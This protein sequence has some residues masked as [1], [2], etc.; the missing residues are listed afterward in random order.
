MQLKF[1]F[2]NCAGYSSSIV[3]L[4]KFK[5]GWQYHKILLGFLNSNES[6]RG[7]DILKNHESFDSC[8]QYRSSYLDHHFS[9]SKLVK[10]CRFST[11][12]VDLY[13]LDTTAFHLALNL[14]GKHLVFNHCQDVCRLCKLFTRLRRLF[15]SPIIIEFLLRM[16]IKC[17]LFI[18]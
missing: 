3:L 9:L 14:G 8:T 10:G 11:H 16:F 4:K 15:S 1:F 6:I 5:S 17:F 7:V 2:Q 13:L 12:Y 18:Y